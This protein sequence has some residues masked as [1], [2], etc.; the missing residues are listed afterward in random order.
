M[1]SSNFESGFVLDM[2]NSFQL[3]LFAKNDK[4]PAWYMAIMFIDIMPSVNVRY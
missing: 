4:M 1:E 2:P 3:G